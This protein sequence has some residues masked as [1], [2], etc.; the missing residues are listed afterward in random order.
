VESSGA[1]GRGWHGP[2]CHGAGQ[3]VRPEPRLQDLRALTRAFVPEREESQRRLRRA[4][5][6]ACLV[7]GG[8]HSSPR[9]EFA[10]RPPP[11][12]LAATPPRNPP[13]TS[14]PLRGAAVLYV[15]KS[16]AG[17]YVTT[18]GRC[19]WQ[20]PT[21]APRTILHVDMDA[22]YAAIEQR[23]R[24]ELRGKPVIVGADP[25]GGQGRGAVA[26]ASSE[27]RRCA[28]GSALPIPRASLACPNGPY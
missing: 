27:A 21:V 16:A 11:G 2:L 3:A 22:F 6:R 15:H 20:N 17:L 25:R 9:W 18:G 28:V 19:E 10:L 8:T 24:P 5:I 26:T 13:R 14:P 7:R 1:I 12:W 23:D 4:Q